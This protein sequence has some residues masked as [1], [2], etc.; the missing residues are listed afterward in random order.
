MICSFFSLDLYVIINIIKF[1][2]HWK[3]EVQNDSSLLFKSRK[4]GK[5]WPG[6]SPESKETK[7]DQIPPAYPCEAQKLLLI[8]LETNKAVDK[9]VNA[10]VRDL[11]PN[12]TKNVAFFCA[13]DDVSKLD[14]LKSIL[15]GNGVNVLDDVFTCQVKGGLFKAGK[16]SDE[17]IKKQL[18]GLIRLLILS[19]KRKD[20]YFLITT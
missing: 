20:L 15:K 2:R 7:G 11:N 17:D 12:R 13:G 8:G 6:R 1:W 18:P 10:F 14:E 19:C 5:R 16:V 3:H 4:R 9:Q